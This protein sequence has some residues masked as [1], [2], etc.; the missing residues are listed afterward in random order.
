MGN[1]EQ[2]QMDGDEC[3][4]AVA[5]VDGTFLCEEVTWHV[6]QART[7]G[8]DDSDFNVDSTTGDFLENLG[9]Y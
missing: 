1:S 8:G 2:E 7:C 3:C 5:V 9:G 6:T 4:W